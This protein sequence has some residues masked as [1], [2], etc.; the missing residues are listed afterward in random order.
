[1]PRNRSRLSGATE[2][3]LEQLIDQHG[4]E[5]AAV[6]QANVFLRAVPIDAWRLGERDAA[7]AAAVALDLLSYLDARS[8]RAGRVLLARLDEH[9]RGT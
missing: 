1:M 9:R 4:L 8:A 2:P 6:T 7:P 3:L 5:R